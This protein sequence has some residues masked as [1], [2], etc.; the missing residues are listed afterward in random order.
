[1]ADR[2]ASLTEPRIEP[3]MS[4]VDSKFTLV[5]LSAMRAREIND[6]YN[7]LGEGL[8]RIVPPQVTSVSRKPLSIALEEVAA[9][10]IEYERIEP[11]DDESDADAEAAE[12]RVDAPTRRRLIR[13]PSR[14]WLLTS[15][16]GSA[17]GSRRT[18]RSRCA[19]AW[20]TRASTSRRCSPRTRSA[21]SAR[22]RSPRWPR[23]RRARR[24]ST[25]PIRSR[26]P[27]SGRP[28]TSSSS[29]PRPPSCSASTRPGIS[30]DLLTATLLATRA[31]V[32]V[33]PAMHT[34]MWEHPAVQENL[35]HAAPARRARARTRVGPARRRRRRRRPPRRSRAHRRPRRSRCSDPAHVGRSAGIARAR[36]R[37]RDPGAD[38]RGAGRSRTGRRAS[39]ATRS[40]RPRPARGAAVTL[41]TTVERPVPAGVAEVVRVETAAEM[42][43]AVM[44][45]APSA[46]RHRHGRGGGRLPAQGAERHQDQEGGRPARDRPRAHPRLPR[47]PRRAQAGRA[48]CS[49]GSRPR[50]RISSRTPPTSCAASGSTSSSATT[51]ASA[52]AGFEVDTNRGV[53]LDADGGVEELPLLTKAALAGVILDRIAASALVCAG[54][55]VLRFAAGFGRLTRSTTPFPITR[56][57]RRTRSQSRRSRTEPNAQA[58]LHVGVGHRGPPRQDGGPDQRHDARRRPPGGPVRPG[59]LRDDGHDR[60]VRRRRRDQHQGAHRLLAPRPRHDLRDRLHRRRVRHRRQDLR[61]D[62]LDRR[63]VARHRDGCRQGARAGDGHRRHLRRGRRRRPGHDVRLRVR[64]DRRA[65][66]DADLARAPAGRAPH[67]GAQAGHRRLPPARRQDAGV[68]RLRRRR[69]EAPPHRADLDAARRR[70]QHRRRPAA[71]A[72]RARHP[73]VAARSSSRA[74]TSRSS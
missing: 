49:S 26:T 34:E 9:G 48:R 51:S 16:S 65:D 43:D 70:H 54:P 52:D 62:R 7:Q 57:G 66:A 23:S 4:E 63:A 6:Y 45:R 8:G 18:R 53:L 60:P 50:P 37:R 13:V 24:S 44:G 29:R 39:R 41:V 27:G 74:T 56:P 55:R 30:D 73:T 28:P 17:A 36:H 58:H 15:S 5:T 10:K 11:A 20:S 68:D 69:T 31:P 47:R 64:R 42:E 59:R 71:R 1:M 21:S 61:R 19:G 32:L 3:L 22:S 72:D 46:G 12:R 40:P 35:D 25:V 38:R 67:R 14:P 2:R 33:C